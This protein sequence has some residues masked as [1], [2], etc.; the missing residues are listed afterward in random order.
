MGKINPKQL[1]DLLRLKYDQKIAEGFLA[2]IND[3]RSQADVDRLVEAIK[4]GKIDEAINALHIQVTA[5]D[6]MLEQIRL[7]FT[8]AGNNAVNDMPDLTT[9]SG[10]I[11]A[12]VRFSVRNP[13]A[14]DWLRT[15]SS[16]LVTNITDDQRVA[17]RQALAAGLEAGDNPT[18]T[19]LDIVGRVNPATGNRDG[20]V[21]GLTAQQESFVSNAR[22]E[23]E[24]G[25]PTK[26][27]AYLDRTLRDQRFDGVVLKAISNE[28]IIDPQ[29]VEKIIGR[30]KDG[31]LKYRGDSIGR[32]ESLT[33]LR[34]GQ[35]E[36]Y[37]QAIETGALANTA[38]KKTWQTAGDNR[39]RDSHDALDGETVDNI[40][41]PFTS[42]LSGAEMLFPGDTSLGAGPEEII[43]CRCEVV[44]QADFLGAIGKEQQGQQTDQTTAPDGGDHLNQTTT[45]DDGL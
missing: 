8:E 28:Q 30:Y 21:I 13:R 42:P 16:E 2:S 34:S 29:N 43:A 12:V 9:N 27:R 7:G 44:Y 22:A 37:K 6:P 39:V 24:S 10:E 40:D 38:V 15:T 11:A 33:A 32:T 20:G 4:A 41:A 45:P 18:K 17:V 36:A 1:F 5:F 26:L 19:A 35:Y 23:L 25:D 3:L 14:E 31:L